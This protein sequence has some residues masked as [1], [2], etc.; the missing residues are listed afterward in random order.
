MAVPRWSPAGMRSDLGLGGR[1]GKNRTG[2]PLGSSCSG[3]Y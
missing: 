3:D 2:E 1:R